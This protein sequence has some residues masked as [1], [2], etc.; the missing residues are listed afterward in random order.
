MEREYSIAGKR[1]ILYEW[2]INEFVSFIECYK[3]CRDYEE[4][5]S[6]KFSTGSQINDSWF[7]QLHLERDEHTKN[8]K[9]W[10]SIFLYLCNEENVKIRTHCEFFILDH[11]NEKKYS[12]EFN[13]IFGFEK[14]WGYPKFIEIEDFLKS[15][16]EL[17]PN[18]TLTICISLSIF[19][20]YTSIVSKVPLEETHKVSDSIKEL[21]ATKLASDITLVVDNKKF[22]AH[23]ALL[24]VRSPVFSAMFTSDMRETKENEVKIND[25]DPNIFEKVLKFIYIDQIDQIN[26]ND[27]VDLLDAAEKFQLP[28]LKRMCERSVIQFLNTENAVRLATLGDLYHSEVILKCATEFIVANIFQVSKTLEY[29]A[30]KINLNKKVLINV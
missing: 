30:L 15:R 22:L 18:D 3:E 11:Q 19:G 9:K 6:S 28:S 13:T 8:K 14:S 26:D 17:L 29:E 27:V 7:L 21:Y 4:L 20:S 25:I 5:R 12:H 10:I 1:N 24:M 2:K 23:K 16:E